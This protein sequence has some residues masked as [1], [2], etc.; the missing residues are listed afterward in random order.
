VRQS[1]IWCGGTLVC[2]ERARDCCVPRRDSRR[3]MRQPVHNLGWT[4]SPKTAFAAR[5]SSC[6][7]LA[8][9]RHG[10]TRPGGFSIWRRW[11]GWLHEGRSAARK[12]GAATSAPTS[13]RATIYTLGSTWWSR[14]RNQRRPSPG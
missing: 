9:R 1:A 5:R 3:R 4:Q 7:R 13:R 8:V 14:G 2:S 12:A 10:Q 6:L 11:P